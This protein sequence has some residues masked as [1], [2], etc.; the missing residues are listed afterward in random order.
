MYKRQQDYKSYTDRTHITGEAFRSLT[1]IKEVK[2]QHLSLIHICVS[3][4]GSSTGWEDKVEMGHGR[5]MGV[6]FMAQKT[7]GK[8]TGWLAYTLAKSCLLYTSQQCPV[9]HLIN[10]PVA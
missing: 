4:L 5:S 7:I 10:R 9:L 6:E 1:E 2:H 8:T 3:F